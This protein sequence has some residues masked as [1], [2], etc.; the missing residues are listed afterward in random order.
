M[1]DDYI[2]ISAGDPKSGFSCADG[3]ALEESGRDR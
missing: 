3:R 1:A 2:P